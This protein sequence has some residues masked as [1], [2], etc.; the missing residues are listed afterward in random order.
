MNHE[1]IDDI[2]LMANLIVIEICGN[3]KKIF[4]FLD[5]AAFS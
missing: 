2:L 4:I 3:D 1:I 5:T